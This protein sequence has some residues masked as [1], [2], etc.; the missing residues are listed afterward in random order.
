MSRITEQFILRRTTAA[1]L[2]SALPPKVTHYVFCGLSA[3][4]ERLYEAI[5]EL[6]KRSLVSNGGEWRVARCVRRRDSQVT[7]SFV[8]ALRLLCVHPALCR[9]CAEHSSA[10][11]AL[12]GGDDVEREERGDT[13]REERDDTEREERDDIEREE[14]GD[15]ER[16]ERDDTEREERDDIE[17]EERGDIEREERGDTEREE[18]DDDTS[19]SY[20]LD[21]IT[22]IVAAIL[23]STDELVLVISTYTQILNFLGK[24]C[25]ARNWGYFRLDGST[26]V[27]QRQSLVNAFN[28]R[29]TPKRLFLLSA[30]AGGVGLNITGASRVVMVEPA[31]N[32]AIDAQS[33]ARSWRFGQT[34]TVFVYRVFLSGS[35]E[36]VI[37]QRQL[38]KKDIADVAVDHSAVG[39]GKLDRDELREVFQLKK[40]G[41]VWEGDA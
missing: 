25:D 22:R 8:H 14:R 17:R 15:T 20:K 7:L 3:E 31:W 21:A 1:V 29:L 28:A 35:I 19:L 23:A 27:A 39:E 40:V 2:R 12:V 32:P 11:Q 6:Q 24:L 16:E 34:R 18:R 26:D 37:L 33:V 4:Q 38:L 9:E 36:E 10:L 13:E 30:R 41:V 5:T